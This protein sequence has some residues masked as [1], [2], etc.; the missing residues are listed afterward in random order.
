MLSSPWPPEG[1]IQEGQSTNEWFLV[2]GLNLVLVSTETDGQFRYE[3]YNLFGTWVVTVIDN[4]RVR[5]LFNICDYVTNG[6]SYRDYLN[7]R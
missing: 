7:N 6:E 5:A 2:K 4:S 3:V 1:E